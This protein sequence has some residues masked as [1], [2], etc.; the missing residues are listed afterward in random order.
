MS[1]HKPLFR[2]SGS[3]YAEFFIVFVA[4]VVICIGVVKA[5]VVGGGGGDEQ[6]EQSESEKKKFWPIDQFSFINIT[7]YQYSTFMHQK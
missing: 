1:K 4:V 6:G 7:K 2:L 3:A 5:S